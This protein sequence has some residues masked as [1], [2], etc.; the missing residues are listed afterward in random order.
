MLYSVAYFLDGDLA[1]YV[2]LCTAVLEGLYPIASILLDGDLAPYVLFDL[3]RLAQMTERS[4]I[5]LNQ[6]EFSAPFFSFVYAFSVSIFISYVTLLCTM[7]QCQTI[8][9][10][11]LVRLPGLKKGG[12]IAHNWVSEFI[13]FRLPKTLLLPTR[14][15]GCIQALLLG[16]CKTSFMQ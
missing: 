6:G 7:S 15:I 12:G 11:V 10:V 3:L 1:P 14:P 2:Y 8:S 4:P 16:Y 5:W 9:K 13:I